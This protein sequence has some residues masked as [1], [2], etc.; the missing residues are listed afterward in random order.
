MKHMTGLIFDIQ[1]FSTTDGPGIRTTV[2]LKGCQLK[3]IWCHNPESQLSKVQ[4]MFEKTRCSGCGHCKLV[5]PANVH[6]FENGQHRLCFENCIRCGKCA[7]KCNFNAL[8]ISGTEYTV[9]H[10]LDIIM[11]DKEFYTESGGGVTFSGGEPTLQAEFLLPVLKELHYKQINSALDTS[12]YA[13][14]ERLEMLLP[15]TDIFL[16]DLK[17]MKDDEHKKLTGVSNECILRNLTLL[18][19]CDSNVIIRYPMIPGMND[20]RENLERM[21]KFL[22]ELKIYSL[23]LLPY[24]DYG[25]SKAEAIGA[26]YALS[27]QKKPSNDY[28]EEKIKFLKECGITAI[29]N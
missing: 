10:L 5:C 16:Y 9:N 2:F 3:C 13:E 11:R 19:Q 6:I 1:R 21:A 24:H 20:D 8:K 26:W 25:K 17:H 14:W 18:K 12:G 28:I 23:E 7:E 15:Y 4:L 29:M 22:L 27:S